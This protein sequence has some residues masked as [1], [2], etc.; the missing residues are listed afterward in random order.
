MLSAGW[1]TLVGR[2]AFS[3]AVCPFIRHLQLY[4]SMPLSVTLRMRPRFGN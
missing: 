3:R 4:L 1:L 2:F